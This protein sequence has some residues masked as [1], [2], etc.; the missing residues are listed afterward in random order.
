MNLT[1][2]H[3]DGHCKGALQITGSKSE[4]NRLLLLQALFSGFEVENKS[5]ADDSVVMEA[6]LKTQESTIDVHHAGTA[7]RFF[8]GLFFS[9]AR[10]RSYFD[11]FSKNA[12]TAY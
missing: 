11:R 5:N 12:R 1:I 10:Q 7:M 3:P 2:A 4:T 6:A 8:N 9:P